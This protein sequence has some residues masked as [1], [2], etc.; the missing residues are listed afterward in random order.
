M[1]IRA[2]FHLVFDAEPSR[3]QYVGGGS[4][5]QAAYVEIGSERYFVK[6]KSDAPARFFETEARN[7]ELL[8]SAGAIRVPKVISYAEASDMQ[9]A[10]LILEWIEESRR[11][12]PMSFSVRF[13]HALA[14]LH[15][16]AGKAFGLD[17]DNFI[18]ELPQ[19]N[20]TNSRWNA[21]YRDSRLAPQIALARSRGR[22]NPE[23]EKRLRKLLD[24]IDTLLGDSEATPA[25]LHGDLW[26]GNFLV[27]VGNQ[28]VLVDPAVYYGNREVEIA[29]TELFGGFPPGFVAAYREAY[30]LAPGY[31]YRR[32]L[33]QLYPLLVHLN[34]F[35]ESYGARVDAVCKY[36]LD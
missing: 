17:Y 35:G 2:I 32:P 31:E 13:A 7:L 20:T 26:S 11:A 30:P 29:F 34:L 24:R 3:V 36:Y 22:L 28:P 4:I 16:T 25:L 21:F 1:N 23:R 14:D 5:N 33:Y 10:Y 15:R 8:A 18:G 27:A 19:I 6:W 12:E 9:P